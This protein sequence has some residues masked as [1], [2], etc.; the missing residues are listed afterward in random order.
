MHAR[1]LTNACG[2]FQ[3]QCHSGECI[4]VYNACDSIPQCEDGSDEGP[5]V[6]LF[7]TQHVVKLYVIFFPW[8]PRSMLQ[9]QSIARPTESSVSQMIEGRVKIFSTNSQKDVN[10]QQG[11]SE[12]VSHNREDPM[13]APQWPT[14]NQPAP[15][16]HPN[17]H[18]FN[19]KGGLHIPNNIPQQTMQQPQQQLPMQPPAFQLPPY[20]L[21]SQ[22]SQLQD[23]YMKAPALENTRP[24]WQQMPQFPMKPME[25][26]PAGVQQNGPYNWPI[27]N[28]N[29]PVYS[30]I[31]VNN[32][33]TLPKQELGQTFE[34]TAVADKKKNGKNT[35]SADEKDSEYDDD[36]EE[37]PTEPPPKK[38]TRKHKK[39][40]KAPPPD[41]AIAADDGSAEKKPIKKSE[42]SAPQQLKMVHSK[43]QMEFLDHDGDSEKPSGAALSL[44]LGKLRSFSIYLASLLIYSLSWLLFGNRDAHNNSDDCSGWMPCDGCSQTCSTRRK[45]S[46]LTRR[47]FLSERN[48]FIRKRFDTIWNCRR[49]ICFFGINFWN[50]LMR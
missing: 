47:R 40:L 48:V 14:I 28:P 24:I 36:D 8:L 22:Q 38:K 9:C 11:P 3:F 31:N 20:N 37:K 42:D 45:S 21:Q 10:A 44:T 30:S 2:R 34:D 27:L 1:N 5:E 16:S 19:H 25:Q 6:T 17:G 23:G 41:V 33:E 35:I 13:T 12:F 7:S 18:I 4:A 26:L 39:V 43:L 32:E 49:Y 15:I 50:R 46:I 29:L